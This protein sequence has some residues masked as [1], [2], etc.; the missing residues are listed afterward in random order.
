[1]HSIVA[2]MIAKTMPVAPDGHGLA[3]PGK[4]AENLATWPTSSAGSPG[5]HNSKCA[6]DGRGVQSSR[7]TIPTAVISGSKGATSRLVG[8][9]Y[10]L[11]LLFKAIITGKHVNCAAQQI[12][13]SSASHEGR[14]WPKIS[15]NAGESMM[16]PRVANTDKA[17]AGSAPNPGS[18]TSKIVALKDKIPKEACP[19]PSSRQSTA[20]LPIKLARSTLGS[21][22]TNQV[23]IPTTPIMSSAL[24]TRGMEKSRSMVRIM[25]ASSAI[26]EPLTAVKWLSPLVFIASERAWSWP[27]RSP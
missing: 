5:I 17:K 15:V 22:P 8:K 19:R 25:A 18:T 24:G 27:E 6:S 21:G 16:M 26:F 10:T 11:K 9:E 2:S 7:H 12:E 13:V 1:M 14:N 23:N 4:E 20:I 3:A